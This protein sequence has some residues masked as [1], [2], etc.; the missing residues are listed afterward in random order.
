MNADLKHAFAEAEQALRE[1][2]TLLAWRELE[3]SERHDRC[4]IW[5]SRSSVT[6]A[7]LKV[8]IGRFFMLFFS[9][10]EYAG[11]LPSGRRRTALQQLQALWKR[12]RGLE[13][14]LARSG[15]IPAGA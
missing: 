14:R 6:S 4:D 1:M 12:F 8:Q 2:E 11:T 9:I 7:D 15:I 3:L 5:L 13:Q 10:H